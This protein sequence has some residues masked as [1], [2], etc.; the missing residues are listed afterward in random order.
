MSPPL[1]VSVRVGHRPPGIVVDATFA[2]SKM[3]L[4]V[5]MALTATANVWLPRSL[6]S[7]LDNDAYY[8]LHPEQMGGK[9]WLRAKGRAG[10]LEEM[11]RA[12][13]SWRHAWLAGRLSSRVNWIADARYESALPDREESGLLP[14]FERCAE[15]LDAL[16]AGAADAVSDTGPL[17]DC[18]RDVVAL[19][20]ALQPETAY[21]LTIADASGG[22]PPLA[23]FV[24]NRLDRKAQ[25][26]TGLTGLVEAAFAPAFAPLAACRGTGAAIVQ[27]AAPIILALPDSWTGGEWAG[28]EPL[29][30]GDE[31][32]GDLWR[33]AGILWRPLAAMEAAA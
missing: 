14:R 16:Q 19:A 28:D 32:L 33:D 30:G 26:W 17:D 31:M 25:L 11:A 23:R 4:L 6:Y 12:L 29:E 18:A 3:G 2:L 7:L 27:I 15:A 21:I 9:S 5:T 8:R 22:T 20:A 24:E 10:L 1:P 13:E